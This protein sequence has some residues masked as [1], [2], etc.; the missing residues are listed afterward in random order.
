MQKIKLEVFQTLFTKKLTGN[1]IDFI[2]TLSHMQDERG[3]VCGLHYKEMMEKTGIS[4]LAF[5]DCKKSL[6]EKKVIEERP[7]KQDYDIF[8]VGND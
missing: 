4:T 1:E 5:Y 2:L 6:Q 3:C 7:G 8:L